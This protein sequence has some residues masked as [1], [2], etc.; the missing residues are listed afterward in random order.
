MEST[1]VSGVDMRNEAVAPLLAPLWR[2][3]AAAGIT[4]QLHNGRG[5][6]IRAALKTL[7]FETEL[8]CFAIKA[9]GRKALRRPAAPNP[10]IIYGEDSTNTDQD[11]KITAITKSIKTF[12][13]HHYIVSC[14]QKVKQQRLLLDMG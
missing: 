13:L 12:L 4:P 10:K 2:I 6:P 5:A 8:R 14:S 7:D 9:W 3:S 11:S 1:P